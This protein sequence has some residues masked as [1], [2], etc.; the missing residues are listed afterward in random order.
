MA[1]PIFIYAF[2]NLGPRR[3]VELCGVL[4]ASRHRGFLLGGVGPDGGIDAEVD[5]ILGEWRPDERSPL[6][7]ELVQP[8][9]LVVFQFKHRVTARVG[10][11]QARTQLLGAYR[12]TQQRT[13]EVHATL[14][15]E[16][17]PSTYVLVT[18]VEV[19]SQ[20]R[21]KFIEQCRTENPDIEHYQIIGLDELEMWV[22]MAP[23]VRHLYFPTIFGLP[24]FNLRVE[25]QEGFMAPGY[26]GWNIDLDE[27]EE[28][29]QVSVLNVGTVPSFVSST[30]FRA[31]VDGQSQFLYLIANPDD[32]VMKEVNPDRG[33]PLEPGRSQTYHFRFADLAL[34]KAYGSSVLPLEVIVRD[35]IGNLY[36]EPIP[37]HLRDKIV[38]Y[39]VDT[40]D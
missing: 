22:T 6:L 12:C 32:V 27:R 16:K 7:N 17:K 13:C 5:Q 25:L 37:E 38:S 24:R 29:F 1:R 20:F 36:S 14:V 26:G 10:Q 9:Q 31:I 40:A 30:G 35:E 4:L 15:R 19:N 39:M 34:M 2:D 11:A 28:L 23:E 33:T 18:N 3:F 21:A 8:G